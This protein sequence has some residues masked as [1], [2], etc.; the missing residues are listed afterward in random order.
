M[1]TEKERREKVIADILEERQPRTPQAHAITFAYLSATE[2]VTQREYADA[3]GLSDRSIRKYIALHKAQ[4]EEEYR[5]AEGELKQALGRGKKQREMTG[6]ELDAFLDILIQKGT[7]PNGSTQD[8]KLL[9]EFTGL[10]GKDLIQ[11]DA[12]KKSSLHWFILNNLSTV[13]GY[14]NT[15]ELGINLT[16]TDIIY[17]EDRDSEDNLQRFVDKSIFADTAFFRECTYWGLVFLS[18]Y[19]ETQH[20]DLELLGDAVRLERIIAKPGDTVD[21]HKV[22]YRARR[23]AEG[24]DYRLEDRTK[25]TRSL[26]DMLIELNTDH[27]TTRAEAEKKVKEFLKEGETEKAYNSVK[28]IETPPREKLV[29]RVT[30]ASE[31]LELYLSPDEWLHALNNPGKKKKY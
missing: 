4:Y 15:R 9:I 8:R 26:E 27:K 24:K 16:E 18:M 1:I 23:Y 21:P 20:P 3:I 13:S 14:M 2:N 12:Q 7:D 19:N 5:R 28:N 31:L 6:S 11:R 22:D 10:S 30:D 25:D 17:R 29:Q